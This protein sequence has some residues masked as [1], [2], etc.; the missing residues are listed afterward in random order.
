MTEVE[1]NVE[2]RAQ[3]MTEAEYRNLQGRLYETDITKTVADAGELDV[4]VTTGDKPVRMYIDVSSSGAFTYEL[5]EDQGDMDI[6][7]D[8]ATV[9]PQALNRVT[10]E[11]QNTSWQQDP[12]VNNTGTLLIQFKDSGTTGSTTGGPRQDSIPGAANGDITRILKPN[13]E[14]LLKV[15]DRTTDGNDDVISLFT[16]FWETN[17]NL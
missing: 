4:T 6:L 16:N 10:P 12:T 9:T 5:Y 14:Y 11:P 8:G 17:Y 3:T 13:T 15:I 7:D 1:F 2:N